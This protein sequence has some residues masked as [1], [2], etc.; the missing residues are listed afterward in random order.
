MK[1]NGR[2]AWRQW[3]KRRGYK[4]RRQTRKHQVE[5][6]PLMA[7]N[8][9]RKANDERIRPPEGLAKTL[10]ASDLV[11]MTMGA[12]KRAVRK[13]Q[14]AVLVL[15]K[16]QPAPPAENATRHTQCDGSGVLPARKAKR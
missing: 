9:Q 8:E 5:Y 14:A 6:S 12:R 1:P 11:G 7:W 3:S 10:T 4:R 13:A 2:R 15:L 16:G